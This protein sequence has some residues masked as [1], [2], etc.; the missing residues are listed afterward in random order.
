MKLWWPA[1]ALA[2]ACGSNAS[3]TF[4]G[5]VHGQSMTPT[6][7]ISSQA[8][9][10]FTSGTAPVAALFFSDAG[11]LCTKLA[12]NQEPRS[13]RALLVF[14]ADV[15]S[16]TGMFEAPSGTGTFPVFTVG[17]G[18]P[19]AHFAVVS[20]GV[21]DAACHR[22][23][24]ESADAVAGSVT[25]TRNSAGT[26]AGSYDLTFDSGDHVTGTFD[27]A[28]C[29]AVATYLASDSHTCG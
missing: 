28:A 1:L 15:D 17:S 29:R 19:P 2:V 14:L 23:D 10:A 13:S 16:T 20:F 9:V 4:V 27:T 5:T 7:A 6:D 24:A 3:A 8:T 21:N 18:G 12:A 25:L 22:V 26:Y 11:A